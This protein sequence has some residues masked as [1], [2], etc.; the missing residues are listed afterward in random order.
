MERTNKECT[1]AANKEPHL[2]SQ[3]LQGHFPSLRSMQEGSINMERN[4]MEGP[5]QLSLP[6]RADVA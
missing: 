1:E 3:I 2:C 6:A 5:T 4:V